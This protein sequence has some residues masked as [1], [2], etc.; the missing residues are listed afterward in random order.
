MS[1]KSGKV[2]KWQS[3]KVQKTRNPE[4]AVP[5]K[6]FRDL[7]VWQRGMAIA[8]QA[9]LITAAMPKAEMFGLTGQIRRAATSIPLNIAEGFG[10]H[11]RPEFLRSLR[12][13]QG[14]LLEVMTA[15][16]IASDVKMIQ[17]TGTLPELLAEEDRLLSSLIAKLEAKDRVPAPR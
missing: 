7:L 14:S 11:T 12:I 2:A 17:S 16:E 10:R 5:I 8:R 15:V 4:R 6:T 1:L 13:A 3:G 9:Y